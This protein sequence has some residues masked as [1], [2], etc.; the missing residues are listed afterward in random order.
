MCFSVL[1]IAEFMEKY[2]EHAGLQFMMGP[3]LCPMTSKYGP[4]LSK[5]VCPVDPS[6]LVVKKSQF[7]KDIHLTA[8]L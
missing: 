5:A 7:N 8:S 6:F 3:G 1:S 2:K 4:S